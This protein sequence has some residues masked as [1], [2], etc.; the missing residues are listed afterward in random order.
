MKL[1]QIAAEIEKIAPL[2]LALDWDNVG[3]L[4]GCDNADVKKVLMTIDV[5]KG[6]V[7]EAKKL[8][9]DT[10][11]SYHPVIWDGLKRITADGE[12]SHI[13][14]L[15]RSGINVFSFHTAFDMAAGGVNDGLAAILGLQNP[16]PI[17]DFVDSPEGTYYKLITFELKSI[18]QMKLV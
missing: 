6:V 12:T 8:K 7:A 10:I 11:L 18:L 9:C 5:T 15:V 14:D 4:I 17:G 3:L 2:K 1:K 13:Y 16:E